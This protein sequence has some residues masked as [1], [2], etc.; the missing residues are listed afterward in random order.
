ML[1]ISVLLTIPLLAAYA[2]P[3]VETGSIH[4]AVR[5]SGDGSPLAQ[6][7]VYVTTGGKMVDGAYTRGTDG[8]KVEATTDGEGRYRLSGLPPGPYLVIAGT[9]GPVFAS[10]LARL[11]PGQDIAL[12][13]VFSR[14][15]I[16]S[17]KVIDENKEPLPDAWVFLI[18]R[19]YF[20]GRPGYRISAA[21]VAN[22]KG[23]YR[24]DRFVSAGVSYMV[25]AGTAPRQIEP[26]SDAPADPKL[27]K[28]L[29][30]P[31]YYPSS[32]AVEGA[33]PITLRSGEHR[34]NIDIEVLRT[35]NFCV[36]GVA[37]AHGRPAEINFS[38][39]SE[40]PS[41]GAH[42]SGGFYMITP[43]GKTGPAGKLR[44]CGLTPGAYNITLENMGGESPAFGVTR[45]EII[46]R[47]VRG[48]VAA[49]TGGVP[50]TGSVVL[51]GQAPEQPMTQRLNVRLRP[52][53][54]APFREETVAASAAIPGEFRFPALL[55]DDYAIDVPRP[56][57]LYVKD[58]LYGNASVLNGPFR[59]GTAMTG[60][61]LKIV[62]AQDG[63]TWSAKVADKDGH[64]IP[65]ARVHFFPAST[66]NEAAMSAWVV[67][68]QTDA[69]GLYTSRPLSPGKYLAIATATPI[70]AGFD[71]IARLWRA[72]S[73]AKEIEIAPSKSVEVTLS[74]I[75][76]E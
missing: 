53:V 4:G 47:D 6:I 20:V 49:A 12:D 27:R 44:L 14:G 45:V 61:E 23:E 55:L 30:A 54:R 1:R 24:F 31:T 8:K 50:V 38:I 35:E 5:D 64:A 21:V 26:V 48:I 36:E 51:E 33:V 19:S 16:I 56:S 2:Q 37:E 34:E 69:D 75:I 58:I 32:I 76:L 29:P 22:D 52:L 7:P 11:N 10:K 40:Q 46:D 57:G 67:S 72:R 66:A 43:R 13:F 63:G 73:R 25:L 9:P 17:G 62:V 28:K 71:S 39:A 41:A 15:G 65:D 74:P 68:G 60:A 59:F 42:A 70:N 3:A 18:S